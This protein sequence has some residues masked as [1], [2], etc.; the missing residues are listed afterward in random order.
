[1]KMLEKLSSA[2]EQQTYQDFSQLCD[3]ISARFSAQL[4]TQA[5]MAKFI[6]HDFLCL[7]ELDNCCKS[8]EHSDDHL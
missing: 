5:Q 6:F 7:Y 3:E 4:C 8:H 1:M 2:Q